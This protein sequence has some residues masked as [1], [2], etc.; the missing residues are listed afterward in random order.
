MSATKRIW[1]K[2]INMRIFQKEYSLHNIESEDQTKQ[3]AKTNHFY[4]VAI[5]AAVA[6]CDLA[7][8]AN[9]LFLVALA[10]QSMLRFK[11]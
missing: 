5:T 9:I 10:T 6:C 11:S 1:Q 7:L 4:I 2:D 3:S 8:R